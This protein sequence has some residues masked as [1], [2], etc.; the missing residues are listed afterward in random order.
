MEVRLLPCVDW[1]RP[2]C[3]IP[4]FRPKHT[5]AHCESFDALFALN[6]NQLMRLATRTVSST[7]T[8]LSLPLQ[9]VFF[10]IRLADVQC[11]SCLR[12]VCLPSVCSTLDF[13][14]AE[15][16]GMFVFWVLQTACFGLYSTTGN[17]A[18][19]HTFIAM[20]CKF[21]SEFSG[22]EE[23]M[24]MLSVLFYGCCEY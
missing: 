21:L 9:R 10:A 18:A 23:L 22:S 5:V 17:L 4:S 13:P 3:P 20:I 15:N 24:S 16:A 1:P 7:S 19:G 6:H 14:D 11:S 12:S 8:T 2:Y